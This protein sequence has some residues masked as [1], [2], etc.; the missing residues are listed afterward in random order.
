MTQSDQKKEDDTPCA[1]VDFHGDFDD[2]ETFRREW[3][4]K[5]R[6]IH[7]LLK[8][9]LGIYVGDITEQHVDVVVNAANSSLMGGSGVDGAI[10][11]AAGPELLAACVALRD[12]TYPNGLPTGEAVITA[13]GSLAEFVIH[14]VGPMYG[15]HAGQEAQLLAAC[16]RNSLALALEKE[17]K[18]IA[19]PAISTGVYGYPPEEAAKVVFNTLRDFL[20]QDVWFRE[21]RLV[22]F[23][24]EDATVFIANHR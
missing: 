12:S 14:T 19:F 10:H 13:G 16:Y 8:G 20:A 11:Q 15:R 3:N 22:F 5:R 23:S 6:P 7:R 4:A 2:D 1:F 9:R 17:L 18:T 24:H 21:V